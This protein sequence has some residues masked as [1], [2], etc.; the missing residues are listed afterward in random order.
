MSAPQVQ[1][2]Q[3]PNT[4]GL[5][6]VAAQGVTVRS[7]QQLTAAVALAAQRAEPLHV[8][9]GGSNVVLPRAL[10]GIAMRMCIGGV[11]ARERTAAGWRIEVGAGE[12]WQGFVRYCIGQGLGGGI[13]NLTLI[14]GTVGAA[15]IQNI[16]AYGVEV[17]EFIEDVE[18]VDRQ[19]TTAGQT[20]E[21]YWLP[22][23]DC[24]FAYRDSCFKQ[25]PDRWVVSRVR[26]SVPV[27]GPLRTDYAGISDELVRMG[28]AP[29]T[30]ALR[31]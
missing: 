22:A 7:V 9:G 27:K 19:A 6:A 1:P 25:Q 15:P 11:V 3:L 21:P 29:E 28:H 24:A 20:A 16:G 10:P 4:L 17:A 18:V 12:S 13:E 30:K 5:P 2:M 26:F 14:P 8:L 23:S 31:P